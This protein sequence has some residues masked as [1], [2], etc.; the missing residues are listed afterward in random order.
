MTY[1]YRHTLT[2][3]FFFLEKVRG[4]NLLNST[5]TQP[6]TND[7]GIRAKLNLEIM[8]LYILGLK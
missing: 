7:I 3:V 4:C 5:T 8:Y 1:I 6:N 2:I